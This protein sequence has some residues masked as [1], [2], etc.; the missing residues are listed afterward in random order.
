[1]DLVAAKSCAFNF[2]DHIAEIFWKAAIAIRISGR[3]RLP[4]NC[5]AVEGGMALL[6]HIG[7]LS[8]ASHR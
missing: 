8:D 7:G 2:D 5:I 3:N 1:V 6:R 4:T